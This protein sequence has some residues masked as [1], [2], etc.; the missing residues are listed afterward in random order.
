MA[1]TSVTQC[2]DLFKYTVAEM[3]SIIFMLYDSVAMINVRTQH[4]YVDED[5]QSPD[6]P[7]YFLPLVVL[8]QH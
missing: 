8:N 5:T 1:S 3:I 7:K 6:Q 2:E 4:G